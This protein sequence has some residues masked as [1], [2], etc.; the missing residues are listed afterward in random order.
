MPKQKRTSTKFN[1]VYIYN[2]A[3]GDQTYFMRYKKDGKLIEERAGRKTQGWS[4]CSVQ[5]FTHYMN[6]NDFCLPLL[7]GSGGKFTEIRIAIKHVCNV[8]VT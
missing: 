7:S 2:L 5:D 4:A 6:L 3:N 8:L 1:G